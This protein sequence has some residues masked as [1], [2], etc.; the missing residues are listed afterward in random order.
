MFI[1]INLIDTKGRQSPIGTATVDAWN[2]LQAGS[3]RREDVCRQYV[4]GERSSQGQGMIELRTYQ[5]VSSQRGS[6]ADSLV[7]G[8]QIASHKHEQEGDQDEPDQSPNPGNRI[9]STAIANASPNDAENQH[10]S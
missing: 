6:L 10:H 8:L 3:S 1:A 2:V 5:E 7:L 4:V 9:I